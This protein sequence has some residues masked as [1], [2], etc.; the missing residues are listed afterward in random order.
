MYIKL[1]EQT[2]VVENE[3]DI[4]CCEYSHCLRPQGWKAITNKGIKKVNKKPWEIFHVSHETPDAYYGSP[5]EGLGLINCYILKSNCRNFLPEEIMSIP[6]GMEGCHTGR[7]S[8][9][10]WIV[11]ITPVVNLL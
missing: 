8:G 6:M 5:M 7:D 9:H 1:E 2:N 11:N 4:L 10:R 3:G